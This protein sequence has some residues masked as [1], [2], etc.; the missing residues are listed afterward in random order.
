MHF[1]K[2]HTHLHGIDSER[3]YQVQG[4]SRRLSLEDDLLHYHPDENKS[5]VVLRP[6]NRKRTIEFAHTSGAHFSVVSTVTRLKSKYFWPNMQR[7][8]ENHIQKCRT[9]L[10]NKN[11]SM[12]SHAKVKRNYPDSPHGNIGLMVITEYVSKYTMAFPIKS[13][14]RRSSFIVFK[15]TAASLDHANAS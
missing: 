9:C 10:R 2:Y 11:F 12:Q 3:S 14:Q 8:V 15:L 6:N 5:L 13:K 1:L 4:R 7:D